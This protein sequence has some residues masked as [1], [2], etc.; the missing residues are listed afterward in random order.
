MTLQ[1]F[2]DGQEILNKQHD[3]EF[4]VEILGD[5]S[6]NFDELDIEGAA[7]KLK[8]LFS[9]N[10]DKRISK[11]VATV[12]IGAVCQQGSIWAK[13]QIKQLE[14]EQERLNE[15]FKSI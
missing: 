3:V 9:Y 5:I 1:Q 7:R 8:E 4:L 13:D 10:K 6:K 2:F 14:N 11:N 12:I 15:E